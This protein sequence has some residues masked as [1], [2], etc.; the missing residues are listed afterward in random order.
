MFD[1]MFF[2][3]DNKSLRRGRRQS[4]RTETCR[5]CLVWL[6]EASELMFNGVA[7]NMTPFGLLVRMIDNMPLGTVVM[8]QL[9]RDEEFLEPLT[10]PLEGRVVRHAPG[11]GEFVDHGMLLTQP[12]VERNESQPV[13]AVCRKTDAETPPSRMHT[14]D[15][16]IGR[17]SSRRL[18]R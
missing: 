17:R 10:A 16:D 3:N 18:G 11:D 14:M 7:I 5:P 13:R 1:D 8:V 4:A 2:S 6:K 15:V 12:E 9:M